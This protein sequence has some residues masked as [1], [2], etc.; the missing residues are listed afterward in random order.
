MPLSQL[1]IDSDECISHDFRTR[2]KTDRRYSLAVSLECAEHIPER[3]AEDFIDSLVELSDIV[4][5]SAAIPHQRGRSHVNEQY[6]SYWMEK[7]DKRGYQIFDVIRS[8]VWND[9]DVR[10]F[11]A[12]NMFLYV[13]RDSDYFRNHE[14]TIR[15]SCNLNMINI[16][17]PG[18]WEDINN[19]KIVKIMDK[20]HENP[21]ISKIYYKFIKKH[22]KFN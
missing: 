4:L 12:Q 9:L 18:I 17:N 20:M 6:Q 11:Y 13:K 15:K 2:F 10:A 5:F 19:Y 7:F 21:L 1:M 16:V 3:N 22:L 8:K 14:E